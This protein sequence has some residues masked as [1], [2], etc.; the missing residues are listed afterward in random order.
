MM[1]G[2]GQVALPHTSHFLPAPTWVSDLVF[3]KRIEIILFE[4]I[5]HE[6]LVKKVHAVWISMA[7]T[8]SHISVR[9]LNIESMEMIRYSTNSTNI[10]P[11][12][13]IFPRGWIN[14]CLSPL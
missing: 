9:F 6:V 4:I 8:E 14:C 11:A 1:L 7:T 3:G 12:L 10:T 13:G 5:C 2:K